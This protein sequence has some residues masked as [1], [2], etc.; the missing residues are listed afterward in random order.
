MK[1]IKYFTIFIVLLLIFF[2]FLW[3][4]SKKIH[5]I[6]YGISFNQYHATYM[7]FDWRKMYLEMLN[8][9]KPKYIR[10]AAMWSDVESQ[11]GKFDFTSVD[12][13]MEEAKKRNVKV[14]LVVGQKAPRWPECHVPSS[15]LDKEVVGD[16]EG[17]LMA[18]V[19]KV[20][21][22]YKDHPA[23]ELWQV[24]N[25]PFINFKF[26]ECKNYD[27]S[28][29]E[30]EIKLVKSI[31]STHKIIITD[32]GELSFWYTAAKAGDLFGTTMYRIVRTPGGHIFNY[33]WLPAYFYKLKSRLVG[34]SVDEV[35]IVE[36]QA[37]PWFSALEDV[38]SAP[39]SVQEETMN[40]DRLQKHFTYAKQTGFPR[41]YL[42]GVEWWYYMKEKNKDARYWD[43]VKQEIITN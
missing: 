41:A 5:P 27:E 39:I 11:K 42:W 1:F 16:Y 20:V 4:K 7:G 17:F 25:E 40:P 23:L 35:Y 29:V 31:D 18:Y 28:K 22:R 2:L 3:Y 34:R 43:A 21:E 6:E 13:M 15:W 10:V 36:L 24:E 38:F 9:L 12:F 37:E 14:M 33:D 19:K 32:S 26:G 30:D 8:E